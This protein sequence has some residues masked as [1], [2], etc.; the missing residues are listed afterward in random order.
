MLGVLAGCGGAGSFVCADDPSCSGGVC[1]PNGYCSFGDDGCPSGLRYGAHSPSGIAGECVEPGGG[2]TIADASS[3]ETTS[4]TTNQ[5][6]TLTTDPSTTTTDLTESSGTTAPVSDTTSVV[7]ESSS[8]GN[9]GSP[10]SCADEEFDDDMLDDWTVWID[11]PTQAAIVAGSFAVDLAELPSYAGLDPVLVGV[12]D[13]W[14]E[15]EMR[16]VPNQLEGTQVFLGIG[17]ETE[18]YM[19]LLETGI[20]YVRHDFDLGFETLFEVPWEPEDLW[21]RVEIAGGELEFQR[22]N[23]GTNWLP[24]G[25]VQPSFSLGEARPSLHAGTWQ[26]VGLDPGYAVFERVSICTFTD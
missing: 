25:A 5:T 21:L 24:F 17:V 13:G 15:V 12:A 11:N 22:S 20:L 3:D 14:I 2:E 19:L 9:T 7:D 6:T 26:V 16:E 18:S 4:P 8:G 10:V 23:D 1:Q